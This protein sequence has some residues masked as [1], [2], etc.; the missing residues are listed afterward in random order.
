MK[1]S[2]YYL[3]A[4]VLLFFA[5]Q[6]S[7]EAGSGQ[8]IFTGK[9]AEAAVAEALVK[10]GAGNDIS[11]S[12]QQVRDEDVIASAGS[13]ITVETD[14]VDIDAAH[15]RWQAVLLLKSDGKNLA[16]IRLSGHFDEMTR[17][18]V[19]KNRMQ[20]PD[21]ISENDIDWESEP[22]SRLR[23]NTVTES[24]DLIGK[25]PKHMISPG[26][27]I[28][29]DEIAGPA[30]V[31]KG[32]QVTLFY[33]SR[34][35]EIRTFGEALESGARGDVIRVRNTASKFIIQGTVDSANR[36]VVTSPDSDAAEAM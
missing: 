33:K 6:A 12:I 36:V 1:R 32:A 3:S 26:R 13:A 34:N 28:R 7:A 11:V 30:L 23:K 9:D 8:A 16:P 15:G 14:G 18:P 2:F 27:P 4:A 19:L 10:A 22:V 20:A 5:Q 25:S 17:I 29:A 35:L 21:I 31:H 24:R